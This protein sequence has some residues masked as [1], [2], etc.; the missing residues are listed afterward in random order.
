[1]SRPASLPQWLR[2]FCA[3]W[4]PG[5]EGGQRRRASS[6]GQPARRD[7]LPFLVSLETREAAGNLLSLGAALPAAATRYPLNEALVHL[8]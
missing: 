7:F 2:S 8:G 4:F 1:M 6:V 3:Q 5:H